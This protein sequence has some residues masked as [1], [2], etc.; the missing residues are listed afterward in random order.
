VIAKAPDKKTSGDRLIA[1]GIDLSG[2]SIRGKAT[3]GE[4][5]QI[6]WNLRQK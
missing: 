4:V 3:R 2:W 6:M 5:A 1:A